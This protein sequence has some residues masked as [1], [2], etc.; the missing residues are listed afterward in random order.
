MN[1]SLVVLR[2]L[3]VVTFLALVCLTATAQTGLQ[4]DLGRKVDAIVTGAL[5]KSGVTIIFTT[6]DPNLVAAMADYVVLLRQGVLLAA[7]PMASTLTAEHLSATYGIPVRVVNL[8]S[9]PIIISER[10]STT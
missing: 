6:H 10:A 5:A 7:G 9:Q 1:R 3:I 2:T 4:S 8:D